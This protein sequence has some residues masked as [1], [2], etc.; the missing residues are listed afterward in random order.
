MPKKSTT[1]TPS[2]IFARFSDPRIAEAWPI[3]NERRHLTLD[4]RIAVRA[5]YD[6]IMLLGWG[7]VIGDENVWKLAGSIVA[8][9][10]RDLREHGKPGQAVKV[11][12]ELDA[13]DPE[14]AHA[15][16]DQIVLATADAKVQAAYDRLV[17]R[18]KWWAAS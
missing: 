7:E 18:A 4:E 17:N 10:R 5:A 16:A 13:S 6:E 15:K 9:T 8:R 14:A 3:E 12:D 11:L 1:L 2:L